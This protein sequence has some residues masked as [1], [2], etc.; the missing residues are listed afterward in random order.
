MNRGQIEKKGT[1][2]RV[3]LQRRFFVRV[4]RSATL[5]AYLGTRGTTLQC[6]VLSLPVLSLR[7]RRSLGSPIWGKLITCLVQRRGK[8]LRQARI[9]LR[10]GE[11]GRVEARA[12]PGR[13]HRLGATL[14]DP[15]QAIV[16]PARRPV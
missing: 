5:W 2:Q 15:A 9:A 10:G 13:S 3:T 16:G 8:A 1:L 11:L 7:T 6:R 12:A 4:Y 14:G